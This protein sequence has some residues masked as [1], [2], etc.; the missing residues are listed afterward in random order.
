V[1]G[2]GPAPAVL[3][4]AAGVSSALPGTSDEEAQRIALAALKL[5]ESAIRMNARAVLR[6]LAERTGAE[7]MTG[8]SGLNQCRPDCT[9][10]GPG[11]PVVMGIHRHPFA[12]VMDEMEQGS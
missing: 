11:N 4:A 8:I 12:A 3:L 9:W 6:D 10:A 1:S 7:V 2:S 5:A